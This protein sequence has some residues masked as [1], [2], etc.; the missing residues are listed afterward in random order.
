MPDNDYCMIFFDG[1]DL[2]GDHYQETIS[3][4]RTVASTLVKAYAEMMKDLKA[5][6]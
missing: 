4:S 6:K 3:F 5:G 2:L 1:S